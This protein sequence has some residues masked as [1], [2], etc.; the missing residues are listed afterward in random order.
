MNLSLVEEET[1]IKNRILLRELSI[2]KLTNKYIEFLTKFNSLTRNEMVPF[3]KEILNE[4]DII[5]IT[6]LKAE[7]LLKLKEIDNNYHS[8]LANQISNEKFN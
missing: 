5:N 8:N 4:I 7:N 1:I 3:I 2:K 6:L